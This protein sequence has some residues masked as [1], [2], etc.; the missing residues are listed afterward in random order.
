MTFAQ[1]RLH[2]LLR[3]WASAASIGRFPSVGQ[4]IAQ[5]KETGAGE[6]RKKTWTAKMSRKGEE[7]GEAEPKKGEDGKEEH[8]PRSHLV[9]LAC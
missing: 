5:T 9:L 1:S 4:L 8:I 6:E 2:F 3:S 7:E